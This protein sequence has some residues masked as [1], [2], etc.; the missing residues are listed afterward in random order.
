MTLHYYPHCGSIFMYLD[1]TRDENSDER[2]GA[3]LPDVLVQAKER[4]PRDQPEG[5]SANCLHEK[6]RTEEIQV[7][8]LVV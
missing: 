8:Q 1:S 2:I 6:R 4:N 5:A 7:V 3:G